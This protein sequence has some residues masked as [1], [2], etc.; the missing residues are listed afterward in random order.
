MVPNH[1][2]TDGKGKVVGMEFVIG[3]PLEVLGRV[4]PLIVKVIRRRTMEL[5]GAG[6]GGK[7]Y[8][9]SCAAAVLTGKRVH[10]DAGFLDRV[11]RRSQI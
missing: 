8:L 11:R 10:L 1:R 6:F 9:Q 5:V 4:H 7:G 2:T 3:E